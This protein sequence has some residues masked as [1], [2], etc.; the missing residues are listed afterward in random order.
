MIEYKIGGILVDP[1]G[2]GRHKRANLTIAYKVGK[3]AVI[4][5]SNGA[6]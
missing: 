6:E 1:S 3:V 2:R 5:F 4:P